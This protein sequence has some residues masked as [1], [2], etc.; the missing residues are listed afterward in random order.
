MEDLQ[1]KQKN[2]PISFTKKVTVIQF[3]LSI[4]VVY[5]HTQYRYSGEIFGKIQQF[6]FYLIQAAVPMFFMI[7]GYLFYRI[8]KPENTK[9]KLLSRV[10]T[11]VVPYFVWNAIYTVFT[12]VLYKLSFIKNTDIEFNWKILIQTINSDFSPLWFL[13]YLIVFSLIAPAMYY[14]LKNKYLGGAVVASTIAFN[15][16]F[17]ACGVIKAPLDVNSNSFA[18]FNY[19]YVYYVV[20][21]Y[22][23]LHLKSVIEQPQKTKT[24]IGV[25]GV[26][27]LCLLYWMPFFKNSVLI[28][29]TFRLFFVISLW[30][31]FDLLRDIEIKPFL[32]TS[33]FIYCSHLMIVQCMQGVIGIALRNIFEAGSVIYIL[34][35]IAVPIVTVLV[36][37]CGAQILKK[38]TPAVWKILTGR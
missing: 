35:W 22:S 28:G 8:F 27:V 6:L 36:V 29:H 25:C 32:K 2:E 18:M 17:I 11:L 12:V 20:G 16:V 34:E 7:S 10:R 1:K 9:E 5:Q 30:F 13:K 33:F 19:Q 3:V 15:I 14:P 26:A 4:L 24:L 38:Y 23:A 31:A 21:A 37:L